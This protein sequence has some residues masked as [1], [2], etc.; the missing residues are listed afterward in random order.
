MDHPRLWFPVVFLWIL[1]PLISPFIQTRAWILQPIFQLPGLGWIAFAIAAL[2]LIFTWICWNQMGSSWRMGID[3]AEKTSLIVTGPYAYLRH[4]I[5]ALSSALMLATVAAD[6]A[7]LMIAVAIV[8]VVLLQF[9][10]RRE[11]QYLARVH[12]QPY[13]DYCRQVGRFIP[14]G[15]FVSQS[16]G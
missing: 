4:P 14:Y 8:H 2:S 16:R 10:A 3:P 7:P 9:E 6:P 13:L 12:G 15:R 11:E 5:Y 1:I